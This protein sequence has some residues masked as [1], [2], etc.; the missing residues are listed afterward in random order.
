MKVE[1]LWIQFHKKEARF[2][3]E[4][5]MRRT[6]FFFFAVTTQGQEKE[7]NEANEIQA[8]VSFETWLAT[9]VH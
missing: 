1:C 9:G 3:F 4:K 5:K 6:L 2:S 8:F 7:V